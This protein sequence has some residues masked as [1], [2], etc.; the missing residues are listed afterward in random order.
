[1]KSG[2]QDESVHWTPT[3]KDSVEASINLIRTWFNDN[4]ILIH[5]RCKHLIGTLKTA[6][7]NKQ[8]T[9]FQRSPVYGH[10]DAIMSLVYLIRNLDVHTNPIPQTY[11]AD[12]ANAIVFKREQMS[13]NAKALKDAFRTKRS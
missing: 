13:P 9:D 10:A 7:W 1:M 3:R 6:L 8:R 11:G 4:R 2:F 5:P 12:L